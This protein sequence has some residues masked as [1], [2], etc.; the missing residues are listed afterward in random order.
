[1]LLARNNTLREWAYFRHVMLS[2][3]T[4]HLRTFLPLLL[5]NLLAARIGG[6][7]MP[8]A[9]AR[10]AVH[11]ACARSGVRRRLA[12]STRCHGNRLPW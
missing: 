1:M 11:Y 12:A 4:R 8:G 9:S 10:P 6:G 2:H 5:D 7:F 3:F